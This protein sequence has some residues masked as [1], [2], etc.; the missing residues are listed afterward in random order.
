MEDLDQSSLE[1]KVDIGNL[2]LFPL[3]SYVKE[4]EEANFRIKDEP[5]E[6]K[7]NN[8]ISI[9]ECQEVSTPGLETLST[10]EFE[11]L[12][13]TE[14]EKLSIPELEKL[15]TIEEKLLTNELEKLPTP[16]HEKLSKP[17]LEKLPTP[18]LECH[19]KQTPVSEVFI[20]EENDKIKFNI[21]PETPVVIERKRKRTEKDLVD[22]LL[23][24]GDIAP[25]QAI[26]YCK[27]AL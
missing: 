17:E 24:G 12:S 22:S 10:T 5:S 18:E 15:L 23:C 27:I 25:K 8:D 6:I 21:K 26:F 1:E 13:T 14:L 4:T 20:E 11:K 16:E 2:V 7:T 19:K 9:P 3:G